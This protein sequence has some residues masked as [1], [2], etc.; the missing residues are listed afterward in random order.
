MSVPLGRSGLGLSPVVLGTMDR[1]GLTPAEREALVARAL[2]RGV[3]AVDTAPLY[4]F[5]DAERWIGRA[6]RGRSG[7]VVLTKVGLRWE[8]ARGEELFG[9][10]SPEGGWRSVRKDSRPRS[11]RRDVEGSLRRLGLETLDLVQIHHP[12]RETPV[13]ETLETLLELRR[14]GKLR[15]IGV[16]NFSVEQAERARVALGGVPLASIQVRYSLLDRS[17]ES[18]LTAWAVR[19]GVG[20]LAYSPL[21]EGILAGRY[22]D[23][24]FP[25]ATDS[26]EH[27]RKNARPATAFVRTVLAPMARARGVPVASVA[28]AALRERLGRPLPVFGASR[29]E[30]IDAAA[31][32]LGVT[33]TPDELASIDRGLEALSFDARAGHRRR[34][35]AL[36]RVVRM[37]EKASRRLPSRLRPSWG[38]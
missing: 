37:A 2:D 6:I 11:V 15:A 35:R 27:H 28:L 4:E 10:P 23:R 19:H 1:R 12:D 13:E 18:D 25:L 26:A 34:D 24:P 16:S 9:C 21:A 17:S 31:A 22:L 14:E 38:G 7:V 3:I 5:G 36:Q 33:L 32:S 29:P 8:D 20:V 30:H